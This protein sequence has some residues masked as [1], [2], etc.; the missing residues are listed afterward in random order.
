VKVP[1]SLPFGTLSDLKDIDLDPYRVIFGQSRQ[2]PAIVLGTYW[3]YSDHYINTD[4][5]PIHSGEFTIDREM[6]AVRFA[7]PVWKAGDCVLPAELT[8][9]TGFHLRDPETGE[10]QREEIEVERQYGEGEQIIDLPFLWRARSIEPNGC[11]EREEEDNLSK[12]TG[13]TQEY[14]NSWTQHW[15]ACRDKQ[16]V[17]YAGVEQINLSGNIAEVCYRVGRGLTPI[18]EASQHYKNSMVRT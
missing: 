14:L 7:Y 11:S 4:L 13:E 12:L 6:R 9:Y 16:F 8:L 3:P 5:C 15:D 18:T 1:Q 2:P 17:A 10:W